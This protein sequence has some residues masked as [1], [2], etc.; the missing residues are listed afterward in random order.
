[1]RKF[2]WILPLITIFILAQS[3]L[4][5]DEET[6]VSYY[7]TMAYVTS[8][9]NKPTFRTDFGTTLVNTMTITS[10]T[11]NVFNNGQRV[12]LRFTYGDTTNHAANSYPIS[13]A[14]YAPVTVSSF[15]TL[16]PDSVNPYFDQALYHVYRFYISQNYFNTI[17]YTYQPLSSLNTCELVRI[18]GSENNTEDATFPTL[19][20]ELR[21]NASAINYDYFKLRLFSYDLAPLIYEFSSADSIKIKL[22]WS[23]STALDQSYDFVYKPVIHPLGALAGDFQKPSNKK[24]EG[25]FKP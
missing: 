7:E 1:M 5:D 4:N 9:I 11:D 10:D 8:N 18:L 13:I 24:V 6:P 14:E 16:Q 21:H 2:F 15:K 23:E 3:C 25:M 17:F 22:S 19:Y 12:F 20:F